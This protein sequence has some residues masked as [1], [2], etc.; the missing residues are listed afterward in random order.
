[1]SEYSSKYLN[2]IFGEDF[3]KHLTTLNVLMIGVGGIGCELLKALSPYKFNKIE[4]LDLDKIEVSNLNRQ[5]LFRNHHVGRS[6]A[7]VAKETVSNMFPHMEIESYHDNIFEPQYAINFFKKFHIVFMALDNAE[8]RSYVNKLCMILDLPLLEAG[9]TGHKGQ[10]MLIKKGLSRCYSCFPKPKAKTYPVCTIRTFPEKPIHCIIWG[11]HLFD[12]LF[13]P[14]EKEKENPLIDLID[15]LTLTGEDNIHL[16]ASVFNELFN[17]QILKTKEIEPEKFSHLRSLKLEDSDLKNIQEISTKKVSNQVE[18]IQSYVQLFLNTFKTL[19]TLK[20]K[21]GPIVFDKDDNLALK[22]V[23]A[24][25]NAR[26]YAFNIPLQSE[27]T[28]KEMAGNIVPT[29]AST[30]AIV[31]AIQVTE[32]IKF[33][34]SRFLAEKNKPTSHIKNKELY[35]QNTRTTKIIEASL[36]K[37][38][39]EC[40]VCNENF[41]PHLVF[42]NFDNTLKDFINHLQQQNPDFKEFRLTNTKGGELYETSEDVDEDEDEKERNENNASKTLAHWFGVYQGEII[43]NDDTTG[44]VEKYLLSNDSKLPAKVFNFTQREKDHQKPSHLNESM[45]TKMM[46]DKAKQ[47]AI[48]KV[49]AY[50][51]AK[52]EESAMQIEEETNKGSTNKPK[53]GNSGAI[54]IEEDEDD[55]VIIEPTAKTNG[56]KSNNVIND[57]LGKRQL[58]NI[59]DG[60]EDEVGPL[61]KT[62]GE[63]IL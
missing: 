32:A 19:K 34:Q 4:I 23:S 10:A 28:I 35:V 60:H 38:N 30:N 63:I 12:L 9:T 40:L 37:E 5:F 56:N 58:E 7:H 17:N 20:E 8:A 59:E 42:T 62:K 11:K 54:E 27:F 48:N 36:G 16:A 18:D 45:I 33:L 14:Q 57:T 1:M 6:K 43:L 21:E 52:E 31:A 22:F 55:F 39:P 15:S 3:V 29:I 61:K 47:N 2:V 41:L 51:K 26:A 24:I 53:I 13:G 25:S 46:D 50:N 44:A 49:I